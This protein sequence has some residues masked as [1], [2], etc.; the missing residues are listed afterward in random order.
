MTTPLSSVA[1]VNVASFIGSLGA[2][3]L[4]G[5]AKNLKLTIPALAK[6]WK[7]HAGIAGYLLSSVFFMLGLKHGDLSVLY[8]MV[9]V[10]YIWTMLWAKLFFGEPLTQAKCGALALILVGVGLLGLGNS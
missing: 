2:V 5:G 7:L 3:G 4:K 10:G 8:P 9:S 1:L 6:N